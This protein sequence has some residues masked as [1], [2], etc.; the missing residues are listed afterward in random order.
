MWLFLH[1]LCFN[2]NPNPNPNP[3]V[4]KAENIE[5]AKSHIRQ[6]SLLYMGH[7]LNDNLNDDDD[8][9]RELKCLFV[10]TNMLISRFH[11]CS[12]M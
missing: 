9:Y 2:R 10:R 12:K 8:I 11:H 3:V 5:Y 4:L 7:V 6:N 1:I